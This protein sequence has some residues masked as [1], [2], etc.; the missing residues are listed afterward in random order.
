MTDFLLGEFTSFEELAPT[1][2]IEHFGNSDLTFDNRLDE[3]LKIFED[4]GESGCGGKVWIA[5]ELL[6]KYVL[7]K[8][9]YNKKKCI[10]LGS[11]TGLVGLTLGLSKKRDD[12]LEI[13]ITDIDGLVPLMEKNIELNKLDGTVIAE[14]LSWGDILPSYTDGVDVILAA[15]CVYLEAA[16]P[17]LEKTLLDLTDKD[18]EVLVLMSYRKR[19]KADSKF[20]SKIKKNFNVLQITD[21]N[22]YEYYIKQRVNLFQLVRKQEKR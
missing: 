5:G 13:Y 22:D 14:T 19:R 20:F 12:D 8:G 18:E 15:D 1:R 2:P 21:F 4:G 9:I 6:S 16:F 3:P 7:D 17:L 10:E 11:G